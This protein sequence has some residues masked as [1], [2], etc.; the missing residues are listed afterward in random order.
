[1]FSL[2]TAFEMSQVTEHL[3]SV[4]KLRTQAIYFRQFPPFQA[5]AED[6]TTIPNN[7]FDT[8]LFLITT[9]RNIK[10]KSSLAILLAH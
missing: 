7:H 3:K 4:S 5:R 10:N 2:I 6:E 9:T 1:M 8:V